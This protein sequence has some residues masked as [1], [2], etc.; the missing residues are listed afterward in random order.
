MI[1]LAVLSA[2]LIRQGTWRLDS[3]VGWEAGFLVSVIF[4]G[5][6]IRQHFVNEFVNK[7]KSS[8]SIPSDFTVLSTAASVAG[9]GVVH[10]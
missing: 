3:W 8:S 10:F 7:L 2:C 9:E 5:F 4:C 6:E 1:A